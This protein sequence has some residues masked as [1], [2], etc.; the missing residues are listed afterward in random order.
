MTD[1]VTNFI[2]GFVSGTVFLI[3]LYAILGYWHRRVSQLNDEHT[4]RI[5]ALN[6]AHYAGMVRLMEED[7]KM[8]ERIILGTHD[9]DGLIQAS[10]LVDQ[11]IQAMSLPPGDQPPVGHDSIP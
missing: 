10:D 3:G 5:R 9:I 4:A 2:A 7:R 6:D 11:T 8:T 1:F